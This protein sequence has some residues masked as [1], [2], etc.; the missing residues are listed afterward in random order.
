MI[1]YTMEA[2][3]E[4]DLEEIVFSSNV[5]D[6]SKAYFKD[7]RDLRFDGLIYRETYCYMT[8]MRG[9]QY[10]LS[11]GP[12]LECF[13]VDIDTLTAKKLDIHISML[14]FTNCFIDGEYM[15]LTGFDSGM[16]IFRG[17]RYIGKI[18]LHA[19]LEKSKNGCIIYGRYA[20]Q[21]GKTVYAVDQDGRL[22]RIEWQDI[23]EGKYQKTLVK[24]HVQNFYVDK[25]LGMATVDR[26]GTLSLD[27]GVEVDLKKVDSLAIWMVETCIAKCWIVCG[28]NG[29][30]TSIA[31]ISKKGKVISRLTIK[32][33]L[34]GCKNYF[35][36]EYG[37]IYALQK[38]YV[39]G[40]RGIMMAIESDGCCHL[41][42][43]DY[44]RLSILQ[45]IDSIV[46]L[47]RDMAKHAYDH[48]VKSVAATATRGE[49]IV[50][51]WKWIRM[52]TLKL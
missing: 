6:K 23:K 10:L 8:R 4:F 52:I 39:R 28:D 1:F 41:I 51:G 30:R 9:S 21:V 40:T 11:T 14:G 22:Y 12:G 3:D 13:A 18:K 2:N 50:C 47:D 43:V 45:S 29:D 49:F 15:L 46:P 32:L 17:P 24:P 33:T 26:A 7:I 31:S 20:Q 37:G 16:A 44:G 48:I 36:R 34:K 27:N 25:I 5:P 35:G 42:S 19:K 38:V